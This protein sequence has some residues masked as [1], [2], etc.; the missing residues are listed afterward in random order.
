MGW[1]GR[2]RAFLN[3]VATLV[4]SSPHKMTAGSSLRDTCTLQFLTTRNHY[5]TYKVIREKIEFGLQVSFPPEQ[6]RSCCSGRF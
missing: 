4:A 5:P 6:T 2:E 3:K 1:D